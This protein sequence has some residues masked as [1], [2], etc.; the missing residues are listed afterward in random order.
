M[1]TIRPTKDFSQLSPHPF[2]GFP[3]LFHMNPILYPRRRH[4]NHFTPWGVEY[5]EFF[6]TL[7]CA[8]KGLNQL[9]CEGVGEAVLNAA[10]H[11]HVIGRWHC[12]LMVLMPDHLHALVTPGRKTSLKDVVRSF[13]SWTAKICHVSWQAGFFDHRLRD[14]ASA[15]QKWKYVNENPVRA[16]FVQDVDSWPWKFVG[17]AGRAEPLAR[18]IVDSTPKS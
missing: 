5:P 4:L 12:E 10:R 8:S 2:F 18:P 1:V 3:V 9:C 17:R 11:Y 16:G 6:I 13:K 7:C 14:G 15:M